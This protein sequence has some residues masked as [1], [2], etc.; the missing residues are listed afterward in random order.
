MEAVAGVL[1]TT[2]DSKY[3]HFWFTKSRTIQHTFK[4]PG[5]LT[6]A[7]FNFHRCRSIFSLS[8]KLSPLKEHYQRNW[9][10]S[11]MYF[12]HGIFHVL[13]SK[14]KFIFPI[15]YYWIY[16]GTGTHHHFSFQTVHTSILYF[17]CK[18]IQG[19]AFGQPALIQLFCLIC[20]SAGP[21]QHSK[22]DS[23]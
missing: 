4:G 2:W 14:T 11:N 17:P 3:K 18:E 23:R 21:A 1:S 15:E 9:S 22:H 7:G 12:I 13:K 16:F 8:L 10:W 5:H 20:N 19:Q 6:A